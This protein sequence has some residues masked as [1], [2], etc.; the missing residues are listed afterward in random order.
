M[1]VGIGAMIKSIV[2][3]TGVISKAGVKLGAKIISV[4]KTNVENFVFDHVCSEIKNH[5]SLLKDDTKQSF[6]MIFRQPPIN[7]SAD[8]YS[9]V[10]WSASFT[11]Q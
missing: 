4:G 6:E 3:S 8:A 7:N 2:N 9:N 10:R 1:N 11:T 5:L